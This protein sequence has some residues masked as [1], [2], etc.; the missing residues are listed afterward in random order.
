MFP[1]LLAAALA[2]TPIPDKADLPIQTPSL[3]KREVA[4]IRLPNKLE[5]YI[6]S[7]PDI[8]QSAAADSGCV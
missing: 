5:A 8:E 2:Y 6:I 4:K 1:L 3:Q 7:D